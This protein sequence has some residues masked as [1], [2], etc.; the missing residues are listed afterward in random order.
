MTVVIKQICLALIRDLFVEHR[1]DEEDNSNVIMTK[2]C[3]V[4]RTWEQHI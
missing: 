4:G 3:G 1:L 2:L